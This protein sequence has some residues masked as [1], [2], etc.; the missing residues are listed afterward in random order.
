[1]DGHLGWKWVIFKLTAQYLIW[2]S[3]Y[4]EKIMLY[5]PEYEVE[6]KLINEEIKDQ[7]QTLG[8]IK[9]RNVAT[10]MSLRCPF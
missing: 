9:R 8:R 7:E 3:K 4:L 6:I 2:P 1:M 5:E 10:D